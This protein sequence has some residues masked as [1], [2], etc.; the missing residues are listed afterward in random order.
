LARTRNLASG[1]RGLYSTA[2][3]TGYVISDLH[4]FARWSKPGKYLDRMGEAAG[5]A[6]FFVLN[7][8]IFDFR[9][10]VLPGV[11]A[12]I[13]AAVDWLSQFAAAHSDCTVYY[14]M[15]NHDGFAGLVRRL[16]KLAGETGNFEW[17]PAYLRMGGI[18]FTHGDLFWRDGR[19]P[20]ERH[21]PATAHRITPLIGWVYHLIHTIQATR[22]IHAMWP[23]RRCARHIVKSLSGGPQEL[24]RGIT[25]VYCGHTHVAVSDFACQGITFHNT[26]SG[27]RGLR[28]NMRKVSIPPGCEVS[29]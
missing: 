24:T 11:E 1:D 27:I 18:L 6:D 21:I 19:N 23:A 2:M 14:I 10:S 25:D 9:W 8:D 20:F 13:D 17:R 26:G 5:E 16:D 22:L 4:M 12:T 3:P 28:C 29:Q 7:G 15:G